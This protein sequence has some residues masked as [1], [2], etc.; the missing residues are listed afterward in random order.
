MWPNCARRRT[1]ACSFLD[2]DGLHEHTMF[3]RGASTR[4]L[5]VVGGL[6]MRLLSYFQFRWTFLVQTEQTGGPGKLH[7]T[8]RHRCL[9]VIT[10][11][12]IYNDT[13]TRPCINCLTQHISVSNVDAKYFYSKTQVCRAP[14]IYH[15]N[16]SFCATMALSQTEKRNL[17]SGVCE[18]SKATSLLEDFLKNPKNPEFGQR[19]SAALNEAI[20]R[21]QSTTKDRSNLLLSTNKLMFI[22]ASYINSCRNESHMSAMIEILDEPEGWY[23]YPDRTRYEDVHRKAKEDKLHFKQE[24][25]SL[26]DDKGYPSSW[27]DVFTEHSNS[28][29]AGVP[30]YFDPNFMTDLRERTTTELL[31]NLNLRDRAW[32]ETSMDDASE[33]DAKSWMWCWALNLGRWVMFSGTKND[34]GNLGTYLSGVNLNSQN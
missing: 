8:L 12:Y 4:E 31:Q 28:H 3:K 21:E 6:Q 19:L 11:G 15:H 5:H 22:F 1:Y 17:V 20:L 29:M 13:V 34:T 33:E 9:I 27:K 26:I 32:G 10:T 14:D 2:A 24:W 25:D 7:E 23:P 18:Q 30:P 16:P